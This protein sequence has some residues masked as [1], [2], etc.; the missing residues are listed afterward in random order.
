MNRLF[1]RLG[2][3]KPRFLR[4]W[5]T[6]GVVFGL[7]AMFLAVFLL[8]LMIFNT[9]RR[10]QHVEQQVLTPVVRKYFVKSCYNVSTPIWS[11]FCHVSPEV[12]AGYCDTKN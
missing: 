10:E 7:I 11:A 8:S 12:N 3:M 9:F 2:Q 5:F 4:W 1:L 6:F